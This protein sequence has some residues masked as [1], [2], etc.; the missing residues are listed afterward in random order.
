[1]NSLRCRIASVVHG[2]V[3]CIAKELGYVCKPVLEHVIVV[4]LAVNFLEINRPAVGASSLEESSSTCI[5][6]AKSLCL[7]LGAGSPLSVLVP[8]PPNTVLW[9]TQAQCTRQNLMN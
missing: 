5:R 7:I 8:V 4:N 2:H 1:M 6:C 9:H 3:L